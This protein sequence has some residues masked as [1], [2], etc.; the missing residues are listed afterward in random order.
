MI[1]SRGSSRGVIKAERTSV[2]GK[3]AACRVGISIVS[4]A[5][6]GRGPPKNLD[7]TIPLSL[8]AARGPGHR[9]EPPCPG[10]R[11]PIRSGRGGYARTASVPA[12]GCL[13]S[14]SRASRQDRGRAGAGNQHG[15]AA[16]RRV[17][18]ASLA[19]Q[20]VAD[21][22]RRT[23][24]VRG[25]R[26]LARRPRSRRRTRSRPAPSHRPSR[27]SAHP[28]SALQALR[29]EVAATWETQRASPFYAVSQRGRPSRNSNGIECSGT[30]STPA[31]MRPRPVN[32]TMAP[33][34]R[35][36]GLTCQHRSR[37]IHPDHPERDE[38]DRSRLLAAS[39]RRL[40]IV[41]LSTPFCVKWSKAMEAGMGIVPPLFDPQASLACLSCST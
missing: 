23:A 18:V 26:P 39:W 24:Q 2:G 8:A 31:R 22:W 4:S 40:P 35:G 19:S 16:R 14:L 41:W 9:F 3:A 20:R 7:L 11:P 5:T 17:R 13:N 36:P 28:P 32:A 25:P 10:R 6:V 15:I 37:S 27:R 29:G 12:R 38:H 34:R 1:L 21:A 30:F 33:S